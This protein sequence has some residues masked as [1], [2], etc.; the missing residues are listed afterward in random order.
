M[1][2]QRFP[3]T[4]QGSVLLKEELDRLRYVERKRIIQAISDA[5]ALGDLKENAEYHAAKEEQSFIEG[6][7]NELEAKIGASQIIDISN[8]ENQG[9]VIFGATIT[10]T[11]YDDKGEEKTERFKIVG[12]DEV[13]VKANKI[14]FNSPLARAIIGKS[15]GDDVE[16]RT[17]SGEVDYHIAL[18]EYIC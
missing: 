13:N 11:R 5:R 7:I 2:V 10:L 16:V 15:Q 9:K 14:S 4:Q 12:D 8:V 18:V 6:R 1:S 3:M 17:P